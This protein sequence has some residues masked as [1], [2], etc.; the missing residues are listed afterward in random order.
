[1]RR[2]DEGEWWPARSPT[3]QRAKETGS[4]RRPVTSEASRA[5]IGGRALAAPIAGRGG[6]WGGAWVGA[7][8][9]G[10]VRARCRS[11][12]ERWG[13]A[14]GL[15]LLLGVLGGAASELHSLCYFD[16]GVSEPSPGVPQF[17]SV[18][19]VDGNLIARYDSETGK[20]VP[21]ADWMR[22][23]L[24]QRYW[25]GQT[26]IGQNN[27]KVNRVNLDTLRGRYN[28]SGRAHTWQCMVGCDLLEDGSTRG[29][30]QIAYDGRDFIAF[31][32]DT[33]TF[34][35]ADAAAQIT[36]RKWEADGTEAERQKHYLQNTCVEWLR[37][38]VSYGQAV[39]EWKERPTVRVSGQETPG[40]L[41]LHCRAYG[42]Y[43]RPI[44]V[45]WLKDGE[46]RDHETERGSIAPNSDGTYY[47]W[48]SITA[49]PEEK[50]KYRCRVEHASL[51]EPRLFAWE[52]ESNLLAIVLGV[53]V[54]ILAVIAIIV[55]VVILKQRLGKKGY[56]MA[57]STD[58]GAGSSAQ[59]MNA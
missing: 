52:S 39:L 37:K 48:A 50:D 54:A 33:M 44:T 51:P 56:G 11:G 34:T 2:Q 28:Q 13:R 26:Q 27:Q 7:R 30:S 36:K 15:G 1:M 24:D 40:I 4:A 18:G 49:R 38:Y 47:T 16:I 32:M 53:I 9:V 10:P 59:V 14:L 29:Y 20:T 42:F 55:G 19:Y 17:V 21:G 3:N 58:R 22:D 6:S 46:V 57:S 5:A 45:S 31:D 8:L 35:A 23:N 25:D 41:T 12:A 43:P